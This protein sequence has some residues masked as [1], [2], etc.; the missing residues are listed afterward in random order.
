MYV[1][2]YMV[3]YICMYCKYVHVW[4]ELV[5]IVWLLCYYENL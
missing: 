3:K 2:M 5:E 4:G 1:C